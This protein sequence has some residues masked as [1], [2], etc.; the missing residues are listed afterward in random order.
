MPVSLCSCSNRD[1][2]HHFMTLWRM[3]LSIYGRYQTHTIRL[4]WHEPEKST[5]VERNVQFFLS[6]EAQ[7]KVAKEEEGRQI[8]PGLKK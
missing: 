2:L 8:R 4:L 5:V 7:D 6:R 3:T 1:Y